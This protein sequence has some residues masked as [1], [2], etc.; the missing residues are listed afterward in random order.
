MG[1]S[2]KKILL[3]GPVPPPFTGQSIAFNDVFEN[4]A[5][6]K[7]LINTVFWG[8]SKIL[9]T[10][11][12]VLLTFYT[13]LF[14]K[15]DLVYFTCSR[16]NAGFIKDF[17]LI[18]LSSIAN[19]KIVNHLHGA[20]FNEFFI[21]SG[22]LKP[23]IRYSYNR[24][25]ASIILLDKMRDEFKEFPDMKL[26][27][28]HNC[29]SKIFDSVDISKETQ[30]NILYFSNIMA[31]K[32]ILQFLDSAKFVLE[33]YR[34][35]KYLVAGSFFCDD[36]KSKKEIKH[37][38]EKKI[39][40]IQYEFG[41]DAICYLGILSGLDKVKIFQQSSIFILPTF[42]KTEAFPITIIEAM[43][44]GNAIISTHHNYIP[45]ILNEKNGILVSK[46]SVEELTEAQ[47]YFIEHPA[48][49]QRVQNFNINY[50]SLYYSPTN[51]ISQ[52]EKII[53]NI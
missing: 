50:S 20:D 39:G 35:I 19:K 32:G 12:T 4:L 48:I 30:I 18:A 3:Y 8:D 36:I 34:N 37:L 13:F 44:T 7:I 26:F 22:F 42:Y 47:F 45:E 49:L 46:Y 14:K 11:Y 2:R 9:N 15:F 41:S 10:I 43:R 24:V 17:F 28:V 33:R 1:K 38:F 53:S 16:S 40:E 27:T 29:Y 5:F 21:K 51:Y 25:N 6:D 52:I 23:F 31:S